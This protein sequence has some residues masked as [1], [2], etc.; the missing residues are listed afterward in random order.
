VRRRTLL[1]GCACAALA[2]ASVHAQSAPAADPAAMRDVETITIMPIVFSRGVQVSD[3]E[4]LQASIDKMLLRK[5][6]L[7]GYVLDRPRGWS[8]PPDW[9]AEALLPL[10]PAQLPALLPSKASH[11]ALL[12]VER[13]DESSGTASSSARA[14]I[15]AS[16]V[17]VATGK[18]LWHMRSDGQYEEGLHFSLTVG[19]LAQLAMMAFSPDKVIALEHAF[20]RLFETFPERP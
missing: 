11:A 9:T 6:A 13:I 5:L 3:L 10:A 8:V 12:F 7:K 20:A 4:T 2:G 18:V 14:A 19:P 16:I 15:S 17:E 1:A